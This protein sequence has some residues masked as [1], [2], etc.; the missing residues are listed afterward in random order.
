MKKL[1]CAMLLAF[2]S[3]VPAFATTVVVTGSNVQYPLGFALTSGQWCFGATCGTITNGAFTDS[4]SSGTA[5]VTITVGGTTILTIPSVTLSGTAYNWNT[6]VVSSTAMISGN[7]YP[8]IPCAV[9]AIYTQNDSIPKYSPWGCANMP[10]GPTW[11]NSPSPA[12]AK[13]GNYTGTGAPSFACY[14]PCTYTQSDASQSNQAMWAI[15]ATQ[16]VPSK[17]WVLQSAWYGTPQF[18][19][20][21]CG[22]PTTLTG[23]S[24]AGT[25][26]A[27][28]T[29]CTAVITPGF[30]APNGFSCGASDLTTTTDSLKQTAASTA[31]AVTLTG[32]V[33]ANDVISFHC[34]PF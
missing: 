28:A 22:T 26:V 1:L 25:F 5:T 34:T 15:I 24:I 6:F 11:I 32:T 27:L 31:S 10:S 33:V 16:G 8:T 3:I 7:G 19:I 18:T 30:T 23:G 4:V 21:G 13:S 2:A 17:N 14:G 20:S 12:I 29:S 9:G